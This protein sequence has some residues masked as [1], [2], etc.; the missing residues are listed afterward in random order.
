MSRRRVAVAV[1]ALTLVSVASLA[2]VRIPLRTPRIWTTAS[3]VVN[4]AEAIST[5]SAQKASINAVL[6]AARKEFWAAYPGGAGASKS[7]AKPTLRR[8]RGRTCS[9]R[10]L[11]I[12]FRHE[13]RSARN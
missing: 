13:R 12:R 8:S 2:Q 1:L 11:S 9:T 5:Y 4:A 7:S 3:D 10:T 6:E